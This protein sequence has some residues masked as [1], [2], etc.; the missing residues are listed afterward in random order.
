MTQKLTYTVV[1]E[2]DNKWYDIDDTFTNKEDA[3]FFL[4]RLQNRYPKNTYH[5]TIKEVI[6]DHILLTEGE[7]Y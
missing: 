2:V 1:K 4:K 7:D 5:L 6:V 3:V